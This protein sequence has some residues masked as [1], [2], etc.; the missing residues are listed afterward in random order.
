MDFGKPR[1]RIGEKLR[2][3]KAQAQIE[4]GV[5]ERKRERGFAMPLLLDFP[6]GGLSARHLDH[7]RIVVQAH[8]PATGHD[9]GHRETGAG[10]GAAGDVQDRLSPG[11]RR[12][13]DDLFRPG[14]ENLGDEVFLIGRCGGG[15]DASRVA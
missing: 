6:F 3:L 8:D 14:S 7:T 4:C 5:S 12:E 13:V 9:P 11:R 15:V 2:A 10:A 1:E